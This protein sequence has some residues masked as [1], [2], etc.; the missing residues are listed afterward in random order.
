MQQGQ[1]RVCDLLAADH[2]PLIEPTQTEMA[3]FCDAACHHSSWNS[4]VQGNQAVFLSEV[5][6]SPFIGSDPKRCVFDSPS[7]GHPT[8]IR[9][10]P[11]NNTRQSQEQS[12]RWVTVNQ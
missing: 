12:K 9:K 7:A 4:Q 1:E 8:M 2:H 10:S 6:R 5:L 3:D 11:V